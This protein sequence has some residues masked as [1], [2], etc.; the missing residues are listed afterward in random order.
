MSFWGDPSL[1][2]ELL[3]EGEDRFDG[4]Q[5]QMS[6]QKKNVIAVFQIES[7]ADAFHGEHIFGQIVLYIG[8]LSYI[9]DNLPGYDLSI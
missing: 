8:A 9:E 1:G 4:R 2:I 7:R 3:N 6:H 5:L